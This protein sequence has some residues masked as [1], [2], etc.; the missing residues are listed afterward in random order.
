LSSYAIPTR[1]PSQGEIAGGARHRSRRA[2]IW[3][4]NGI[5]RRKADKPW[6]GLKRIAEPEQTMNGR[7]TKQR[8]N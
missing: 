5:P 4:D 3:A 7:A 2:S 6:V 1:L 8:A